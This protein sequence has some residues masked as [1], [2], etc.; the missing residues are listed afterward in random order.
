MKI[1]AIGKI[2]VLSAMIIA[3]A[4]LQSNAQTIN[5]SIG[6][7]TV[8]RGGS[9]RA[10]LVMDIPSELHVNSNRP[11]SEYSIPTTI[12]VSGTGIRLS[13]INFPPG[14]NRKFEFSDNPVNVYEGRV[15]FP[16]TV[17]VPATFKGNTIRVR[18]VVKYQACTEEV[19]Y[20]PKNKDITLTARVL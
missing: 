5:G 19:C 1:S 17:T 11:N 4:A 20:P 9:V 18:A 13:R 6:N 14:K 10:V 2:F 12:T 3:G 16:F 8:K 15:R 7:G